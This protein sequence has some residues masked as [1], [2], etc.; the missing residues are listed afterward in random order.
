MMA[1]V[2][3]FAF[4]LI[5]VWIPLITTIIGFVADRI[6]AGGAVARRPSTAHTL[7]ISGHERG[8]GGQSDPIHRP[9][10]IS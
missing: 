3:T 5:P 9:V 4:M 7:V 2:G 10:G 8:R 6:R 1:L